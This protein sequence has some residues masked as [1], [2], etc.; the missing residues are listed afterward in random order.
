MLAN[1]VFFYQT[2]FCSVPRQAENY[3]HT[4]V[5]LSKFN[6]EYYIIQQARE[7]LYPISKALGR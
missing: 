4:L 5:L 2:E 7:N 3:K 6:F 1:L